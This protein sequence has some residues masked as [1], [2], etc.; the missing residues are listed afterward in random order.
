M[1]ECNLAINATINKKEQPNGLYAHGS[2]MAYTNETEVSISKAESPGI[3]PSILLLNLTVTPKP[4]MMKGVPR[5]FF[6]EEIGDHVCNYK[7]VQVISNQ[8][9][10]CI[11]DIEVFG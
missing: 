8:G 11:V 5:S 9:D 2:V 7:Q 10:D 4:G 3:N 1:S 6:Y